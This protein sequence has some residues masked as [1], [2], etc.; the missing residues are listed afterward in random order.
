MTN[1]ARQRRLRKIAQKRGFMLRKLRGPLS[2]DN[3]GGYMI[4]DRRN[5]VVAG[6]R[7]DLNLDA[8]EAWLADEDMGPSVES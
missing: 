4:V 2:R 3:R 7:F 8:V 5:V 6:E 1:G